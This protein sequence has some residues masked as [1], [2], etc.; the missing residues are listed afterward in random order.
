MINCGMAT[1]PFLHCNTAVSIQ[2]SDQLYS[3][4]IGGLNFGAKLLEWTPTNNGIST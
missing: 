2:N 4:S 1:V 3:V